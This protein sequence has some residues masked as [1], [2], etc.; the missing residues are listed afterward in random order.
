MKPLPMKLHD[1]LN[2][3]WNGENWLEDIHQTIL[4]HKVDHTFVLF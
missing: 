1:V 3:K 4:W 2:N